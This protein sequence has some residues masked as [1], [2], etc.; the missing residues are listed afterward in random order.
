MQQSSSCNGREV[1]TRVPRPAAPSSFTVTLIAHAK[2][3]IW[4]VDL[5]RVE[6]ILMRSHWVMLVMDVFTRRIVG[7]GI[8]PAS[9]DGMSVCHMFNCATAGQSK[10]KYLSTDHDPLFRFHRW[11]ANLRVLEVEEMKSVRWRS[12]F[13]SVRRN[14]SSELSGG[15]TLIRYFFGTPRTWRAS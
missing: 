9:I 13:T 6:S 4:C 10:P 7:F 15:N 1:S 8:A 5:F 11:L 3:S 14:V 12:A 2:D